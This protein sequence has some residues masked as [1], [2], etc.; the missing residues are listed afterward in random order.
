[1]VITDMAEDLHEGGGESH[2]RFTEEGKLDLE[3]YW[4]DANEEVRRQL[5]EANARK[6]ARRQEPENPLI[7]R[8][9]DEEVVEFGGD[10]VPQEEE[11]APSEPTES[12]PAAP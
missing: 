6:D 4:K 7:A 2:I 1:M 8:D 11:D 12:S 10:F 9:G 3:S 5:E